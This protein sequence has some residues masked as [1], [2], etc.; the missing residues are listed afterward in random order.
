MAETKATEEYI[1]EA[2]Q[3]GF[4]RTSTSPASAGFFFVAR[5]DERMVTKYRYPLPLVLTAIEQLRGAWFFTKLDLQSAYDLICIREGDEWKTAFSPISGGVL[6]DA[7]WLC[8]C[9]VSVPGIH[10]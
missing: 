9:S 4:I 5:K 10:Q 7:I 8:Q 3:Q 6:C 2:L 1:H